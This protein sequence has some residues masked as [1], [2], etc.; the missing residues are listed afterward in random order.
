M[1]QREDIDLIDIVSPNHTHAE[2]A[3]AAAEAGKHVIC[4][5]PLATTL[6]D[7]KRML[8]AV[9]KAGVMHMVCHNYRFAPAIQ[10][11]KKDDRGRT[12]RKN[13]SYT[14][15]LPARLVD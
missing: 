11:A 14:R 7:A 12:A 8:E 1:I 9:E 15:S 6:E 2:I 13:L 10:L 3:I 5:K 4:E